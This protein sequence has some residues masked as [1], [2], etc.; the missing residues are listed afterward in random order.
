VTEHLDNR[1]VSD[2]TIQAIAYGIAGDT[3]A[4]AEVLTQIGRGTSSGQ[5][6]GVC[7]AM[8][9][10]AKEFVART[11]SQEHVSGFWMLQEL[12]PGAL[13][14]DPADAF[15]ARFIT[16]H[17]NGDDDT[18]LALFDAAWQAPGAQ[19]VECLCALLATV[20]GLG[21][22]AENHMKENPGV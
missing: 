7:C 9:A 3:D 21:L 20:V 11:S 16:A 14:K 17:A 6:F 4:S 22:M 1:T 19:F 8:A 12:K 2:L 13:M 5:M 15:A 10:A 18:C